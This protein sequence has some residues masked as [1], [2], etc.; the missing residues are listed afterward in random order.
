MLNNITQ[1][2]KNTFLNKKEKEAIEKERKEF[3]EDFKLISFIH[4]EELYFYNILII[5]IENILEKYKDKINTLSIKLK[6]NKDEEGMS[7]GIFLDSH[8]ISL[9]VITN[10]PDYTY[11]DHK[12]EGHFFE[13]EIYLIKNALKEWMYS[14]EFSLPPPTK[15]LAFHK[16]KL[17]EMKVNHLLKD[18]ININNRYEFY[19]ELLNSYINGSEI[20]NKNIFLDMVDTFCKNKCNND[21][22]INTYGNKYAQLV[23]N[24]FLSIK[25]VSLMNKMD[26]YEKFKNRINTE[27]KKECLKNLMIKIIEI[28]NSDD[29]FSKE[30]ESFF[31]I[32]LI[33]H[34]DGVY[35]YTLSK[36]VNKNILYKT[37]YFKKYIKENSWDTKQWDITKDYVESFISNFGYN[38]EYKQIIEVSQEKKL[39]EDSINKTEPMAKN[40]YKKR[41]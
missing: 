40:S 30:E 6:Y 3:N 24:I 33:V 31:R 19:Q 41:L 35:N 21:I 39:I 38:P 29:F 32:K 8:S 17:I 15:L 20:E 34:P 4:S 28:S 13:D 9:N 7:D 14:D 22:N 26:K 11:K 27:Q 36:G 23:D 25:C 5:C 1:K 12:H 37:D 2:L 16:L 10:H 18:E